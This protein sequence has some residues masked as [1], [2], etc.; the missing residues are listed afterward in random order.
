MASYKIKMECYLLRNCLVDARRMLLFLIEQVFL[1]LGEVCSMPNA[2]TQCTVVGKEEA[3]GQRK[4][5]MF[6]FFLSCHKI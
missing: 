5:F 4:F 1:L 6:K 2:D 3:Q